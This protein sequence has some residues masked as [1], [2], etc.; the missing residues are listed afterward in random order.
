MEI[1]ILVVVFRLFIL[2][3]IPV[4][5]DC[6]VIYLKVYYISLGNY[7]INY[8]GDLFFYECR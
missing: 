4:T 3:I 8:S 2:L 5:V 1:L 6:L 7:I